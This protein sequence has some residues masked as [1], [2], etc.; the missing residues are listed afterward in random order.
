MSGPRAKRGK[1]VHGETLHS[2]VHLLAQ[3]LE[4][5]TGA[6]CG[7]SN[8]KLVFGNAS[9]DCTR[10]DAIEGRSKE[11]PVKITSRGLM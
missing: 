1:C 4:Q 5:C 2:R 7:F 8:P 9:L 6:V 10:F 3:A 11:V